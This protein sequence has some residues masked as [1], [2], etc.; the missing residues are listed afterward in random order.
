M[1]K[2]IKAKALLALG[3]IATAMA[4]V[5][6]LLVILLIVVYMAMNP[7]VSIIKETKEPVTY[8]ESVYKKEVVEV[9]SAKQVT[10]KL[11]LYVI[12]N[13]NKEISVTVDADTYNNVNEGDMISI[14]EWI[15]LG[16]PVRELHK[17]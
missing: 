3:Y 16:V 2:D 1:R 9:I 10:N 8:T 12:T 17:E 15:I 13:D 7:I 14:D 5:A 4:A 11:T 6:I